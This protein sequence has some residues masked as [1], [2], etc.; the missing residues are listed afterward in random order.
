MFCCEFCEISKYTFSTEY[1]WATAFAFCIERYKRLELAKCFVV[2]KCHS[3]MNFVSNCESNFFRNLPKRTNCKY[4][5]PRNFAK[6]TY[7]NDCV[8]AQTQEKR[9]TPSTLLVIRMNTQAKRRNKIYFSYKKSYSSKYRKKRGK[10][11]DI[12]SLQKKLL[13]KPCNIKDEN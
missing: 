8:I 1:L 10:T 11:K 9:Q 2:R 12:S 13:H 3:F 5:F 6:I 7:A 4:E